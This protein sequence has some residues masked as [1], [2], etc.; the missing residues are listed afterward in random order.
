M[1]VYVCLHEFMC[2]IHMQTSRDQTKALDSLK[3][4]LYSVVCYYVGAHI[5]ENQTRVFCKNSKQ[6]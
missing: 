1:C 3:L 6:S 2:T 5:E 4:E